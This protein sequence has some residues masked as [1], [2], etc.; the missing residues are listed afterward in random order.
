MSLLAIIF[1][2]SFCTF[3]IVLYAYIFQVAML[4]CLLLLAFNF[5]GI[6]MNKIWN[7]LVRKYFYY[8]Y[9]LLILFLF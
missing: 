6:L 5:G 1:L 8:Y 9:F 3:N 2:L 4:K 7:L